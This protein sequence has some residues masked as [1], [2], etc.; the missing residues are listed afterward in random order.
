LEIEK[1]S[2]GGNMNLVLIETSGNQRYI[3]ATNKLRENVGAS[4]LTYRVG[5]QLV[6][7]AVETE[8]KKK[9]YEDND[10]DGRKMRANLLDKTK[11]PQLGQNGNTVEV[12]TATSGKALLL[13]ADNATA[14]KIIRT[15]TSRALL[16]M[17]GL[18][19]HGAISAVKDDL[20]DVHDAVGK[21][22][23]KLEQVR[24][25]L[26]TNEQRFL[27]LPFVAPCA[28]SGF[29]ANEYYKNDP[30]PAPRSMVSME[31]CGAAN[32]GRMRLE[33]VVYSVNK[34]IKFAGNLDELE[35]LFKDLSWVAIVHADGNGLGEIFLHFN[36]H[37]KSKD[38]RDY[39]EKYRRFSLALDVCTINAAS[40]A[41]A[42]LQQRFRAVEEERAKR[43]GKQINL[44][45]KSIPVV[46]LILGGDDLTVLCDGQYALKFVYEFL[47][48]FEKETNKITEYDYLKKDRQGKEML[49]DGKTVF[50]NLTGIVPEIANSAFGVSRLGICAGVAIAK[51]HFPFHQGYEL[52]EHLLKSA[53]LVKEKIKSKSKGEPYPCSALDYHIL[54]DST[55]SR[56]ED[57]RDQM[58]SDSQATWLYARPYVV[59]DLSDAI[60]KDEIIDASWCKPRRWNELEKRVAA[61]MARDDDDKRKLPNSQLHSLREALY[62]G[63]AEADARTRLVNHRYKDQGF[64]QL[65]CDTT[66]ETLFFAETHEGTDGHATHFL[67]ALDIVEFRKGEKEENGKLVNK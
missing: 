57:I 39:I 1:A 36:Q 25:N 14:K 45:D 17:P 9:I 16:E 65:L 31:K 40:Q 43:Q 51:P 4:E 30:E 37:S 35:R 27:R 26:P 22:H 62:L 13:V 53:K 23:R 28:T 38:G 67:D 12:I 19:V 10:L 42:T 44:N 20:S 7:E 58:K 63:Q 3:Y 59:S 8:T 49:I 15:V 2:C 56:L 18:T 55:A 48:E 61:M 66:T 32:E 46:P 54:Y 33:A 41:L 21:V 6:L 29:P 24:Y 11:N 50:E 34:Q 5:T 47:R 60:L 52:A 64:D